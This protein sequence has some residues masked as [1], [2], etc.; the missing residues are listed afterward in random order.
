MGSACNQSP[1]PGEH[2]A[3]E[4]GGDGLVDAV[5]ISNGSGDNVVQA[6]KTASI[7]LSLMARSRAGS[8]MEVSSVVLAA[9][10]N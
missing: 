6:A 4:T 5:D 9:E 7:P 10:A 3:V 8:K 2:N 1:D